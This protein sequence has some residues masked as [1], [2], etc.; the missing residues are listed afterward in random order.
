MITWTLSSTE[1]IAGFTTQNSNDIH[2]AIAR[3]S[4]PEVTFPKNMPQAVKE[5]FQK[6]KWISSFS[7]I[8]PPA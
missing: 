3:G 8:H 5:G 7:R 2:E 6:R 4:I 1:I